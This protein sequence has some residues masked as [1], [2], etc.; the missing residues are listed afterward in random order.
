MII[1]GR[2]PA[3]FPHPE[4][5][6]VAAKT[7]FRQCHGGRVDL[8]QSVQLGGGD[9]QL[10]L[11]NKNH[12]RSPH[13]LGN[14]MARQAWQATWVLLFRPTPKILYSWRRVLLRIFGAKLGR[15]CIV[16][17]ST[18]VWAPWNLEMGDYACL[19]PNVD[20]YNVAKVTMGDFCVV[21]QYTY[22]CSASH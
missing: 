16:H 2:Q 9:T 18:K 12:F 3:G 1:G 11:M 5:I 6:R 15:G 8:R 19:G 10:T 14:R 4:G 20:C 7:H 17:P 13:D 21:S 22:L